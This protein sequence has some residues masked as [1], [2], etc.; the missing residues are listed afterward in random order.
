MSVVA[1]VALN[2]DSRGATQSL[3]AVQQGARATDNAVSG[4]LKT[5][6]KLAIVLGAI[7]AVKF[8]FVKTAELESQT[9]S[10]EVLTGSAA[11]AK[12]IIEELQQLGAVTPFTS[13]E[14]IDSAKRLQAFGVEAEKVVQTTKRL[15]D[16][17][18][19]TGA[20]LQGLV[21]AYGQVQAKGRLQGEELLQFQ[22]RGVALQGELQ[23]M[24]G[25]SG[26]ELRKALEKGRI[27]AEAVEVAINRLT[28][29]GGKYADGA[30]AQSDTL[31]GRFSTLMDNIEML[32]KKI[33]KVLEPAFKGILNIVVGIVDKIS[34]F[35]DDPELKAY[36][37]VANKIMDQ[38]KNAGAG[39]DKKTAN[40]KLFNTR[41]EIKK[42]T[43][44][45]KA[46]E[47]AGIGMAKGLEIKGIDNNVIIPSAP[48]LPIMKAELTDL[49][50]KATELENKLKILNKPKAIK[51]DVNLKTPA[52]LE[53]QAKKLALEKQLNDARLNYERQIADFRQSTLL[54]IADMERTLQD[55]RVK[56]NFD[57]QQSNLKLAGQGQFT[58]QT[59]DIIKATQ[60]GK[61]PAEIGLLEAARDSAKS[62]NDAAVTRRQ[63]E[64]DSTMKKIQLERTL[65]D[66]KKGIEREIGEM[67]KSYARQTG[68][69]LTKAGISIQSA[70]IK[71]A[72]EVEKIMMRIG[73]GMTPPANPVLPAANS[74]LVRKANDQPNQ[75]ASSAGAGVGMIIT[76]EMTR[77]RRAAT[78][79]RSDPATM[80]GRQG[81][82][83]SR[84]D[85]VDAANNIKPFSP[86]T[87]QLDSNTNDLKRQETQ[88]AINQIL[89]Q[90]VTK[91]N[92]LALATQSVITASESNLVSAQ[93]KNQ[94]DQRT[95]DL[96]SSGTNPALAAQFAQNEQL[97][98]QST[99]ALEK[100]RFSVIESLKEKDLAVAQISARK[101]LI[102][103][104]DE[105]IAKQ[106]QVL[107]G[108]NQ[109]A[110]KQKEINDASAEFTSKQESIKGLVQGI[111]ASIEGGIV[112]A[113]DGAITGA[114]SLQEV[115]S[116]VLKDI[117]KML[118]SFG[119][120]SLLGGIDIGGT[121]IFGGGKA[122]GG[123][124]SSN[125]TYMVGEKGPELFV[126]STAGTIIPAG[127][128]AGIRDAMAN[129]NNGNGAT[130]PVLNM[131]FETTRFGN[132]DYVSRE[133]L[134][135]AMMQTRAEATKAGA[136]RGMT[137]TLDKLQQSPSTRSRV[138][139]G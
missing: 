44:E 72:E 10:L 117:G 110:V 68:D 83:G 97:N 55:Q 135:A 113:I 134:E 90:Q 7:Q 11:K 125:S 79:Q 132:T 70:M 88:A 128:T 131:S 17:S 53:D 20:E 28:E 76:P 85:S 121:K 8:V 45:I 116:D 133:Q 129:G 119:I 101:E 102:G 100:Q 99:T 105:Q 94:V 26:Q 14:L 106:P 32:A 107:E 60:A 78:L 115:L 80:A 95:L 22:E 74:Q 91:T 58:N 67:Q 75:Q 108:L 51:E 41:A 96:M 43:T 23:K 29:K 47:K 118:I 50:K 6:G 38:K 15:A 54:R 124:V 48:V 37:E 27:G 71:G 25:M 52:L 30:I 65:T 39:A 24:Y 137:M 61:S 64:F 81:P 122:A 19:A 5:V 36:L 21:T 31:N 98:A 9:R 40:D 112:S 111:G 46:A 126:P 136:R 4:L 69:I 66:F 92:E 114:K 89:E 104:I 56:A 86:A 1:N 139:L 12:Q 2:I 130:A 18:G 109:Q 73:T 57:L 35:L 120:K 138:G 34:E 93:Q 127:P 49:N 59:I 87:A 84:A 33:G 16:V 62:L 123:P 3:R 63:I 82:L 42:L 77:S 13:T 103:T